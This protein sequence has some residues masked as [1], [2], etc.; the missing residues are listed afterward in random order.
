[1]VGS[2]KKKFGQYGS[3]VGRGNLIMTFFVEI[4]L[5]IFEGGW[6]R[7]GFNVLNLLVTAVKV[8]FGRVSGIWGASEE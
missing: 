8:E 1:M 7:M 5:E 2:R 6:D 3:R 4:T